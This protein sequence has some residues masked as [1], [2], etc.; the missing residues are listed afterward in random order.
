M[1][2]CPDCSGELR[3]V[4][5]IGLFPFHGTAS[6]IRFILML[7]LLTVLWSALVLVLV[8]KNHYAISLIA[9]Y[10]AS[11]LVIYKVCKSKFE[12]IVYECS[13]CHQRFKG[14]GLMRFRYDQIGDQA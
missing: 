7:V 8:P 13:E 12:S 9:F 3:A 4:D 5:T 11:V 2:D 10:T 1:K 6:R 14:S